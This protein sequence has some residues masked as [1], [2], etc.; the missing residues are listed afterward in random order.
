MNIDDILI[1]MEDLL[2]GAWNVPFSGGKQAVDADALRDCI[3]DI[4]LNLPTEI[5]QAKAI[6]ADRTEIISDAKK[7]AEEIIKKAENR[8]RSMVANDEILKQAQTRANEMIS[9]AQAKTNDIRRAA[10]EYVDNLMKRTEEQVAKSL[11]EIKEVR[12]ELV[13][14]KSKVP[15]AKKEAAEAKK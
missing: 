9:Q 7:E 15:T 3:D 13:S 10:D 1:K 6:V 11:V 5:K 12:R 4:K 8:V 2:E 14:V